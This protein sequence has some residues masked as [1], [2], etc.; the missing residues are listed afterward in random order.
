M[1]KTCSS[2]KKLYATESLAVD[3]LIEAR[4]TYHY[5]QSRGPVAVYQCEECGNFHLTSQG[6]MNARLQEFIMKGKLD[7]SREAAHWAQ[8]L[9]KS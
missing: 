7:H 5:P 2:G 3:A 8:K 9:K 6:Q 4:I 1:K